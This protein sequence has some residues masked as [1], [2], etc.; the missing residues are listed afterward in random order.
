MNGEDREQIEDLSDDI[1]GISD[2]I[3]EIS[4]DTDNIIKRI[5]SNIQNQTEIIK[6]LKKT[7]VGIL[8]VVA[9]WFLDKI[10]MWLI[11]NGIV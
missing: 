1:E 4:E 7:W 8:L 11:V 5:D 6:S 2:D 9:L 10:L 3:E